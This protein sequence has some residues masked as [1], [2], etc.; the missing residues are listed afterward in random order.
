MD[1]KEIVKTLRGYPLTHELREA[2]DLIELLSARC[3]DAERRALTDE[4][5]YILSDPPVLNYTSDHK[6][7]AV[8]LRAIVELR[9]KPI[10]WTR[11]GTTSVAEVNGV[12]YT[13]FASTSHPAIWRWMHDGPESIVY[14]SDT[15]E[16]A[17]AAAEKHARTQGAK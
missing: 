1:A 13:V 2:A 6:R 8:A 7:F 5:L 16:L 10:N 17:E 12:T 14:V 9:R 3:D 11:V 15:R 4:E